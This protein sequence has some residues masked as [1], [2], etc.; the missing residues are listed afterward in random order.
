[1]T[2]YLIR[3]E[4]YFFQLLH[5]AKDWLIDRKLKFPKWF[6]CINQ[7]SIWFIADFVG[8]K[9]NRRISKRLLQENKARQIFRKKNISYL[10]ICTSACAYQGVRN[11]HQFCLI[12]YDLQIKS[13]LFVNHESISSSHEPI[14][15][16]TST[17]HESFFPKYDNFKIISAGDICLSV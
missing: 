16:K 10:L 8:N 1:M 3:F 5:V 2:F 17:F 12:T 14:V 9:A 13:S 7:K 11:V 6:C 4:N 15:R